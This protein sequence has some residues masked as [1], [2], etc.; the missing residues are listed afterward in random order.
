MLNIIV[1]KIKHMITT[2]E[3]LKIVSI[4]CYIAIIVIALVTGKMLLL[5]GILGWLNCMFKDISSLIND[6]R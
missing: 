3:F 1:R 2:E 5:V 4:I 6:H